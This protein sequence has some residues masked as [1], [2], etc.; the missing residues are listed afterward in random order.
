MGVGLEFDTCSSS[1]VSPFSFPL[2]GKAGGVMFVSSPTASPFSFP[3]RGKAGMGVG[4]DAARQLN[5]VS[6]LPPQ[7][8][9]IA[10]FSA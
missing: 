3:L 2:R 7:Y 1:T 8:G 10:P 4:N 6:K 5:L 9:K